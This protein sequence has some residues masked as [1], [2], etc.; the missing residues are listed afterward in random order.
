VYG[1]QHLQASRW[2]ICPMSLY[3]PAELNA[4]RATNDFPLIEAFVS[5]SFFQLLDVLA[6]AGARQ[7]EGTY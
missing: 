7:L 3:E 4:Q 2:A 6:F 1:L 5:E